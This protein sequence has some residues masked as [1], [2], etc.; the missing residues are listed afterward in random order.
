MIEFSCLKGQTIAN[1]DT[2]PQNAAIER[3]KLTMSDGRV[4]E[5]FHDQDCCEYV[6]VN[7]ISGDLDDLIGSPILIADEA[8]GSQEAPA[9]GPECN[10]DSCTWT[11]Y[12]LATIKGYV[13]IR[14]LGE[15]NGYYSQSVTFEEI[16][17][18][19]A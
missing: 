6:R 12:R 14:W 11:F 3:I 8:S 16:K 1:I 9:S 10:D 4:Y 5:L 17:Q 7:D 15:S 13:T 2:D 18:R 19:E